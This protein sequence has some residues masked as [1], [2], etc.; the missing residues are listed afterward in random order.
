MKKANGTIQKYRNGFNFAW[1]IPKS[2]AVLVDSGFRAPGTYRVSNQAGGLLFTLPNEVPNENRF[3]GEEAGWVLKHVL[4]A[5]ATKSQAESV[6]KVLSYVRQL[7]TGEPLDQFAKVTRVWKNHE[8]DLFGEPK[9]SVKA[10]HIITSDN[11]KTVLTKE[12]TQENVMLYHHWSEAYFMTHDWG[13]GG[14]RPDADMGRIASSNVHVV[15]PNEGYMYSQFQGGRAKMHYLHGSVPWRM[16]RVCWCPNGIHRGLPHGWEDRIMQGEEPTWC[17]TCPITC[18]EV[19]VA[20]RVNP[21][22]KRVYPSPTKTGFRKYGPNGNISKKKRFE[23]IRTFINAQGG[24]PHNVRYCSNGGRH[25]LG[26]L[27]DEIR[28]P[29]VVSFELHGDKPQNWESYQERPDIDRNFKRRTQ[30]KDPKV[31]LK[32]LRRIARWLGRGRGQREDPAKINDQQL[33]QL[34]ALDLRSRGYTAEVN[35]IL[36]S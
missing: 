2:R 3:G 11:I 23:V 31:F 15:L 22:D 1:S 9:R 20:Y 12:W 14:C 27:C 18:Y 6:K 21:L 16:H 29:Y 17:T 13:I 33:G 24:N 30:S 10:K 36:D 26:Q 35:R 7:Q 25:A 34:V 32:A 19:I 28:I 5:H 8:E 4:D